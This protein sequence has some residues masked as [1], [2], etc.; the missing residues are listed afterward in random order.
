M[1]YHDK[2]LPEL[3]LTKICDSVWW[4]NWNNQ[5]RNN[6]NTQM[7]LHNLELNILNQRVFSPSKLLQN[8][9]SKK[10]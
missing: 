3:M 5:L 8:A 1:T 6:V 4:C 9:E 2:S 7:A 10:V